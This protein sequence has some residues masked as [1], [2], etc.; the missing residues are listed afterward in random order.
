MEAYEV[1]ST[2]DTDEESIKGIDLCQKQFVEDHLVLYAPLY[3]ALIKD[4][5]YRALSCGCLKRYL[6]A[7]VIVLAAFSKDG[8]VVG[9]ISCSPHGP[10]RLL[11][12]SAAPE[13]DADSH[14]L[15]HQPAG[16]SSANQATPSAKINHFVV[17]PEHRGKGVGRLL[18]D[19][20][21]V[22]L[23]EVAPQAAS[24]LRIIAVELN[25]RAIEWYRRL[26]FAAVELY[27]ANFTAKNSKEKTCPL[28]YVRMQLK[29]SGSCLPWA[30]FFGEEL[31]GERVAVA[32]DYAP[33]FSL[34]KAAAAVV[35]RALK[36]K[37]PPAMPAQKLIRS[38]DSAT[39]LHL[40]ENLGQVDLTAK[41]ST[42]H[43][44]FDRP[45]HT[46]LGRSSMVREWN[47]P[48]AT[49]TSR[50]A[51]RVPVQA[52]A[53]ITRSSAARAAQQTVLADTAQSRAAARL[54]GAATKKMQA[55]EREPAGD[56]RTEEGEAPFQAPGTRK[57]TKAGDGGSPA[58]RSA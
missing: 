46:S 47:S 49:A 3:P 56:E 10:L 4:Q 54:L 28:V 27:M 37:R 16:G 13:A 25:T 18:F 5:W 55:A 17:L 42:G 31:C 38:F 45:L 9:Y 7:G 35:P 14:G 26:G 24:D 23:R 1:R 6:R 57:R 36:S 12:D 21:R 50:T 34:A 15:G 51:T 43:A 52:S 29:V 41:F 53:R 44:Q 19:A 11:D 2:K 22:R 58:K 8:G 33:P 32:P 20:L 48:I 40:L 39:G 30:R